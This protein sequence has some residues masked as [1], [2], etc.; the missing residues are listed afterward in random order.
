MSDCK[1]GIE[2]SWCSLCRGEVEIKYFPPGRVECCAPNCGRTADKRLGALPLCAKHLLS[3]EKRIV[4]VHRSEQWDVHAL[5]PKMYPGW[6]YFVMLGDAIKIGFSTQPDKRIRSLAT[7]AVDTKTTLLGL[8][9]GGRAKE[10][11]LHRKFADW[12]IDIKG[13]SNEMFEPC[14]ELLGYIRTGRQCSSFHRGGLDHC[15]LRAL[16]GSLTCRLHGD[17]ETDL[18]D[19]GEMAY[20]L[21]ASMEIPHEIVA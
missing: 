12:R 19:D 16:P 6:V 1:H 21:Y 5:N 2:E 15:K 13:K 4:R 7:Y 3:V 8:E 17:D 10:K 20:R 11:R 9:R 18:G 14:D